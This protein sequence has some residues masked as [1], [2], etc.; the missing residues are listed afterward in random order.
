MDNKELIIVC[1]TLVLMILGVTVGVTLYNLED[2]RTS[3]E[4]QKMCI[5]Q[6]GSWEGNRC[7]MIQAK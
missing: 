4:V 3:A 2:V 7:L 1:V 6:H 5:N